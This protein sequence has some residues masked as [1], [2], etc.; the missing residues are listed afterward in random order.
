MV[1][2][3]IPPPVLQI[4]FGRH[5]SKANSPT[6]TIFRSGDAI[7]VDLSDLFAIDCIRTERFS[8]QNKRPFKP[9]TSDP[10]SSG[11]DSFD[12]RY[13]QG[14]RYESPLSQARSREVIRGLLRIRF[15]V[16]DLHCF[17]DPD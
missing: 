7:F 8:K 13:R 15:N 9:P 16:F 17:T 6:I 14:K 2:P 10:P 1:E 11:R 5:Q 4:S 12:R 3:I